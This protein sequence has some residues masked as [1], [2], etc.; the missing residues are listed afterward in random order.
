MVNLPNGKC[1]IFFVMPG[2]ELANAFM[3][4][5]VCALLYLEM[6]ER[7]VSREVR[8]PRRPENRSLRAIAVPLPVVGCD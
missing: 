5:K 6:S 3:K 8:V 4:G 1:Q 2:S 7:Q